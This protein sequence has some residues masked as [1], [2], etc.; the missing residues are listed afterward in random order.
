MQSKH[1]VVR[2]QPIILAKGK[3]LKRVVHSNMANIDTSKNLQVLP[4]SQGVKLIRPTKNSATHT[5]VGDLLALPF[6][7][8]FENTEQETIQSNEIYA[9][10]NGFVSLEDSIGKKWFKPFKEE[11]VTPTLLNDKSVI[12]QDKYIIVEESGFRK[13]ETLVHTLSI[14]MPWYGLDNTIAGL[15]GFSISLGKAPLAESLLQIAQMGLLPSASRVKK[16]IARDINQVYLSKRQL[17][18]AKLVLAGLTAKEIGNALNLS[19]RT[20]EG[21]VYAIKTKLACYNRSEL[22]LK[23]SELI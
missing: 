6:Q 22:I 1:L 14:R 19:T 3:V 21:Y 18:C 13:D 9:D 11:T 16:A 17:D 20:V 10:I 7:V 4:Y 12:E 2:R 8:Y 5:S 23:L 15:F